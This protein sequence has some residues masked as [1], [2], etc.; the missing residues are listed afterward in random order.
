MDQFYADHDAIRRFSATVGAHASA[1]H[2]ASSYTSRWVHVPDDADGQ[3]FRNFIGAAHSAE[4][5][6]SDGL[7]RLRSL[8]DSAGREL[9]A[10]ADMYRD[11][12]SVTAAEMDARSAQVTSQSGGYG[13]GE[14]R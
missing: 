13:S 7:A 3:I 12:D 5:A 10:A 8:L 1:V 11:T 9:A 6:V 4:S 2:V 14:P